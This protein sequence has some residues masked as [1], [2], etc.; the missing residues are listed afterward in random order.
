MYNLYPD[1]QWIRYLLL[2]QVVLIYWLSYKII[3]TPA[4][5]NINIPENI[6]P[7]EMP[8]IE[9]EQS[10]ELTKKYSKNY[11]SGDDAEKIKIKLL[12]YMEK[13]KP[14]LDPD[15]SIESISA[16]I[17]EPKHNVSRVMNEHLKMNF[18]QFINQYRIR[19]AKQLL[20]DLTKNH[21]S[22]AGI[23]FDCG[24]SSVSSF[25]IVFKKFES[26]TPSQFKKQHQQ[27]KKV[28]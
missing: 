9:S 16:G 21:L 25:N 24:F 13:V 4:L 11:L 20:T 26:M 5:F 19:Q 27:N 22:I 3:S 23:A 17:D 6:D 18:F 28:A 10:M 15:L 14:F 12:A 2:V 8:M 7:E 1:Y